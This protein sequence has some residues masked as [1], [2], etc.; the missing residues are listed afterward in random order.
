MIRAFSSMSLILLRTVWRASAKGVDRTTRANPVRIS[1][2]AP[3]FKEELGIGL[4]LALGANTV[5]LPA[6]Y[7]SFPKTRFV[8]T[9]LYGFIR[10]G[11]IFCSPSVRYASF[12]IGSRSQ[13]IHRAAILPKSIPPA[14]SM[15]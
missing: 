8:A 3:Y 12:R 10:Y 4:R 13:A 11:L 2:P 1:E 6:G 15:G 14:M 9:E 5:P 7:G